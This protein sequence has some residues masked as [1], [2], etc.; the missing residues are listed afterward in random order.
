M[1]GLTCRTG[2][3]CRVDPTAIQRVESTPDT[4]VF[5]VD[6]THVSVVETVEQVTVRIRDARAGDIVSCYE[7]DRGH[8]ADPRALQ[9]MLAEIAESRSCP[10]SALRS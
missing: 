2:E 4:V 6:G 7:L 5:L 8:T 10:A 3:T 9:D 1:I